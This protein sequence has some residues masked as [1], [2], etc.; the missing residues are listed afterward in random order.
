MKG[1]TNTCFSV[2]RPAPQEISN[3]K[4]A[5]TEPRRDPFTRPHYNFGFTMIGEQ[6]YAY[7]NDKYTNPLRR[8][9]QTVTR[10]RWQDGIQEAL[11]YP[12]QRTGFSWDEAR[13]V[14]R[15]EGIFWIWEREY[16][17][18]T[19]APVQRWNVRREYSSKPSSSRELYY[20]A[21]D[22]RYHLRGATEGWL[23][24]GHLVNDQQDLEFRYFFSTGDGYLD[25]VEV[26]A[27]SDPIPARVSQLKDLR[28]R[29]VTLTREFL[30]EDYNRRVLPEA[31]A[32]DQQVIAV[33]KNVVESPLAAAY[34]SAAAKADMDERRRYCLDI[35][36]ELYFLKARDAFYR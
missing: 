36:R 7:P 31:I 29:P 16:I 12:A 1:T 2:K 8:P 23:E 35:A 11:R 22:R 14:W 24:V 28:T 19:G 27:G 20:S 5:Q 9:P 25:T 13:D 26:F 15:W 30:E 33:L 18:N 10:M 32:G 21:V 3:E 17:P 4:L 34:E 6:P